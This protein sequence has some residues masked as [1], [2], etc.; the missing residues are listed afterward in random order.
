MI[1]FV[2]GN[3]DKLRK[4]MRF[5]VLKAVNITISVFPEIWHHVVW[6]IGTAVSEEPTLPIFRLVH[7][8]HWYLSTRQHGVS[9][10]K[11]VILRR[12]N[13]KI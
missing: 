12:V 5:K 10:Q 11:T 13:I 4:Q 9:A 8:T 1:T 3:K 6:Q 2:Y 7:A